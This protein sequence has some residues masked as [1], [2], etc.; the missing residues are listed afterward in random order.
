MKLH[1]AVKV[2]LLSG[3]IIG[4][5]LQ[6]SVFLLFYAS[7]YNFKV[8][9][10][11][12]NT[13]FFI[14]WPIVALTVLSYGPLAVRAAGDSAR[15][16]REAALVGGGTGLVIAVVVYL[17]LG[18]LAQ[19][20]VLGVV[21]FIVPLQDSASLAGKPVDEILRP[22]VQDAIRLFYLYQLGNLLS[23]AGVGVV[24]GAVYALVWPGL[25]KLGKKE[26]AAQPAS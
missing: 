15:G 11:V 2:G 6:V 26:K 3:L 25:G 18:A 24:E 17:I 9:G 21:P 8:P 16:W 22:I 19:V 23:W 12:E 4:L 1:A 13:L 20:M 14:A 7:A 10:W 5:C